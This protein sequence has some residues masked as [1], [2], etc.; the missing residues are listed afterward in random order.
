[1]KHIVVFVSLEILAYRVSVTSRAEYGIG[2]YLLVEC[3]S[4]NHF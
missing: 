2:S 4:V 3:W 1:M